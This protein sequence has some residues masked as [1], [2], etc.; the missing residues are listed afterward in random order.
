M[1]ILKMYSRE[2]FFTVNK[3]VM[4]LEAQQEMESLIDEPLLFF[5]VT[6]VTCIDVLNSL[7]ITNKENL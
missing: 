4:S 6:G 7:I 3:F 1:N 5:C 2:V